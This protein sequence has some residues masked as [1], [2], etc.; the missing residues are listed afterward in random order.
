MTTKKTRQTLILELNQLLEQQGIAYSYLLVHSNLHRITPHTHPTTTNKRILKTVIDNFDYYVEQ[1]KTKRELLPIHSKVEG[2]FNNLRKAV[3]KLIAAAGGTTAASKRFGIS[4]VMVN[5]IKQNT[6]I[7]YVDWFC[8]NGQF[9][10]LWLDFE[11][12]RYDLTETEQAERAKRVLGNWIIEQVDGETVIEAGGMLFLKGYYTTPHAGFRTHLKRF[13][14]NSI[15][16]L[17]SIV[18]WLEGEATLTFS[19]RVGSIED[20]EG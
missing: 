11:G 3:C 20:K 12:A 14:A 5:N 15:D 19:P 13:Q 8:K 17:L 2:Y 1:T 7:R 10:K 16:K 9:G 6:S 4:W 18:Y